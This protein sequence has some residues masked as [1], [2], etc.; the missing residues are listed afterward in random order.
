MNWHLF[1]GF[2]GTLVLF[3]EAIEWPLQWLAEVIRLLW[4]DVGLFSF[5]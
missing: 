1:Q 2:N 3:F 4:A 5:L